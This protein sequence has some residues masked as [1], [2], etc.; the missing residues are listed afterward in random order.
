MCFAISSFLL[1]PALPKFIDQRKV[2][3][4]QVLRDDSMYCFKITVFCV[5]KKWTHFP[6]RNKRMSSSNK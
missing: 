6:L 1:L 4:S 5:Q 3:K 2:K